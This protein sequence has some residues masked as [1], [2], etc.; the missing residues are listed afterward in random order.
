LAVRVDPGRDRRQLRR[1]VL[2][3][4]GED[5][6]VVR[7]DVV[8]R[9]TDVHEGHPAT[10][11]RPGQCWTGVCP[12]RTSSAMSAPATAT[13]EATRNEAVMPLMNVWWVTSA[14]AVTSWAGSPRWTGA[15]PTV[16]A[17]LTAASCA[18][19]SAG[20]WA[21]AQGAGSRL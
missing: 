10:P 16:V 6:V 3:E 2:L 13:M 15:T 7:A 12:L 19:L 17:D 9:F 5:R 1:P 18:G 4:G 11:R 20:R 8:D 14:M 21:A